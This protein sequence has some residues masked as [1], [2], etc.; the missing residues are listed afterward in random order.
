[1]VGRPMYVEKVHGLESKTWW[2]S[3]QKYVGQTNIW[4]MGVSVDMMKA[5]SEKMFQPMK[6]FR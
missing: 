2:P 4:N 6:T 1:M 3:P 5:Q